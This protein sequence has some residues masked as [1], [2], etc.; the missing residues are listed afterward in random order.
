MWSWMFDWPTKRFSKPGSVA[1]LDTWKD[2]HTRH[3][4]GLLVPVEWELAKG[5]LPLPT[6][7]SL[8]ARRE[9][10]LVAIAGELSNRYRF[11]RDGNYRRDYAS[12]SQHP[13]T[14][15]LIDAFDYGLRVFDEFRQQ[16][17]VD[18]TLEAALGAA[19]ASLDH[20]GI[21]IPLLQQAKIPR[22]QS[23]R[24]ALNATFARLRELAERGGDLDFLSS[25]CEQLELRELHVGNDD[26]LLPEL[27]PDADANHAVVLQVVATDITRNRAANS[28]PPK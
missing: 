5:R 7:T 25:Y 19:L 6:K 14:L 21:V 18:H 3:N 10:A 20:N 26:F 17:L 16:T 9:T 4:A 24:D 13:D 1:R 12:D 8:I 15:K 27:R 28:A 11:G 23:Y 22:L 2:P